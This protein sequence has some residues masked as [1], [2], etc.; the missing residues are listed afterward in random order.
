MGKAHLYE[1]LYL[2]NQRTD[3]AA[4]ELTRLRRATE[5]VVSMVF[6]RPVSIHARAA[7]GERS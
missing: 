5:S 1:A 7:R 6:P 3:E 4:R 2:M